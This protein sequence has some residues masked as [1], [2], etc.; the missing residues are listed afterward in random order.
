[1][2]QDERGAIALRAGSVVRDL[3]ALASLALSPGTARERALDHLEA[4][5][6]S[7]IPSSPEVPHN[8]AT[9]GWAW[10]ADA[11]GWIEPTSWAVLALRKLRPSSSAI[12]DGLAVLVDR[13][14]EGGGWNYGNREAFGVPL[15]PYAQTTALS[16]IALQGTPGGLVERGRGA[17]RELVGHE[18]L[19]PLTAATAAVALRL[20][21]DADGER[22][23]EE[24]RSGLGRVAPVD[25]VTTAWVMLATASGTTLGAFTP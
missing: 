5:Q 15:P 21:G 18:A 17:L 25:A 2:S 9:R 7:R 23:G 13:E 16:L 3:T 11:F 1:M 19:G 22:L 24:A 8:A 4:S 20:L 12:A 10:T 6:A 14:C